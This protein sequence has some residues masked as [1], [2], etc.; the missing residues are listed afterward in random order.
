MSRLGVMTDF[1]INICSVATEHKTV[2]W[3]LFARN[4]HYEDDAGHPFSKSSTCYL[5][6]HQQTNEPLFFCAVRAQQS[7]VPN[8]WLTHRSAWRLTEDEGL[9]CAFSDAVG[10]LLLTMGRQLHGNIPPGH[11][12][13]E[14]RQTS[15]FWK[16]TIW[17]LK[18]RSSRNSGFSDNKVR[19]HNTD[20]S[21]WKPYRHKFLGGSGSFVPLSPSPQKRAV[22]RED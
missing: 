13:G 15:P 3:N 11:I 10:E 19:T 8:V 16:A 22:S 2:L 1:P 4:G 6:I 18:A 14:Y 20:G 9:I 17:N 7:S 12:L 5:G 21:E